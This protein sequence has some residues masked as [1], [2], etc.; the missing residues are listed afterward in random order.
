MHAFAFVSMIAK[1][2]K[3]EIKKDQHVWRNFIRIAWGAFQLLP[4]SIGHPLSKLSINSF[5]LSAQWKL[6][7]KNLR[8]MGIEQKLF[9]QICSTIRNAI[10]SILWCRTAHP[11]AKVGGEYTKR[12]DD[13]TLQKREYAET[14]GK[15]QRSTAEPTCNQ[16]VALGP[17]APSYHL[18]VCLHNRISAAAKTNEHLL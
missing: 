12:F 14:K 16:W 17:Q 4:C 11:N 5:L 10:N 9:S 6:S 2:H 15:H 18:C 8:Q 13:T 1:R 3:T 7:A